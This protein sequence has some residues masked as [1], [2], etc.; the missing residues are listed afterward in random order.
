MI[1]IAILI[2]VS[3]CTIGCLA[4][5]SKAMVTDVHVGS[6]ADKAGIRPGMKIT[7]VEYSRVN[8]SIDGSNDSAD[9]ELHI[10]ATG[11]GTGDPFGTASRDY[12]PKV[13]NITKYNML[14]GIIESLSPGDHITISADD[15][16]ESIIF[17]NITLGK[18]STRTG[19][20]SD[21]TRAYL[22]VETGPQ[23]GILLSYEYCIVYLIVGA[24]L[25]IVIISV[26]ALNRKLRKRNGPSEEVH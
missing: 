8:A 9:G 23:P 14:E 6:P 19:R 16:G 4:N 18:L 15:D 1:V 20:E 17:E 13:T 26:S 10:N 11:D 21:E 12:V 2:L 5:L 3:Q 25:F 22:G 24:F 7:S